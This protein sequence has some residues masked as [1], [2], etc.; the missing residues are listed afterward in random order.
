MPAQTNKQ[1]L[2]QHAHT[3]TI[4][5]NLSVSAGPTAQGSHLTQAAARGGTVRKAP[6]M[7]WQALLQTVMLEH[8]ANPQSR[9]LIPVLR[10]GEKRNAR[11]VSNLSKFPRWWGLGRLGAGFEAKTLALASAFPQLFWAPASSPRTQGAQL[12]SLWEGQE[13]CMKEQLWNV[14]KAKA[15]SV[16]N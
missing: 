3:P 16:L 2:K 14:V 4:H 13:D 10:V 6:G 9:I 5:V 8:Q 1:K 15:L 11:E 7:Q 12:S